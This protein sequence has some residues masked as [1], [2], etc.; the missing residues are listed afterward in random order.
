MCFLF[1][2]FSHSS[3]QKQHISHTKIS[4]PNIIIFEQEICVIFCCGSVSCGS[5]QRQIGSRSAARGGW[6]GNPSPLAQRAHSSGADE[7]TQ[8]QQRS[9]SKA[10]AATQWLWRQGSG[11]GSDSG[12][13]GF[14]LV[15]CAVGVAGV[16][17][18]AKETQQL[19]L[20]Q[21]TQRSWPQFLIVRHGGSGAGCEGVAQR[22]RRT[23]AQG[24]AGCICA[25]A[26]VAQ[27]SVA[28]RRSGS[29][30]SEVEGIP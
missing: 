16:G 27:Q 19:T 24:R 2:F 30:S 25:L 21:L 20:Q 28:Q 26:A 29:G 5:R 10:S 1:F 11:T 14:T 8:W 9:G 17:V 7:A 12:C 23:A 18:A 22:Q 4:L 6:S 15:T 13:L 3:L